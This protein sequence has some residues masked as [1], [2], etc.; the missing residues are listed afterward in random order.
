MSRDDTKYVR[1]RLFADDIKVNVAYQEL[2]EQT[3]MTKVTNR[4]L[5]TITT[6]ISLV[7]S[8]HYNKPDLNYRDSKS[9][10]YQR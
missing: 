4:S 8:S 9:Y 10:H 7:L 5:E 6:I 1:L 3:T 2:T